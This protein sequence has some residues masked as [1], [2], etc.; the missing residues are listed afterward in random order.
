MADIAIETPTPK[1]PQENHSPDMI[2]HRFP[3]PPKS[4]EPEPYIEPLYRTLTAQNQTLAAQTH[5]ALPPVPHPGAPHIAPASEW[6][7]AGVRSVMKK[8]YQAERAAIAADTARAEAARSRW[9]IG[10]QDDASV[11]SDNTRAGPANGHCSRD[12]G[13]SPTDA[14]APRSA[15]T[16]LRSDTLIGPVAIRETSP[17][18]IEQSRGA[19]PEPNEPVREPSVEVVEVREAS[20]QLVEPQREPS[21]EFID[22]TRTPSVEIVE[23]LPAAVPQTVLRTE[24]VEAGSP[25]LC[26]SVR[27]DSLASVESVRA[28]SLKPADSVREVPGNSISFAREAPIISSP[29]H[30]S[31]SKGQK[32]LR[33]NKN[34]EESA[35]T[36]NGEDEVEQ[37]VPDLEGRMGRPRKVRRIFSLKRSRNEFER[38]DHLSV[39]LRD[40]GGRGVGGRPRKVRRT[41]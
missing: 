6:A 41:C 22:Q 23:Y 38:V 26:E 16:N 5:A 11:P 29:A 4:P 27:A 10:L 17:E 30:E 1:H 14:N 15:P 33:E 34:D 36:C 31:S 39:F 21:V 8:R 25:A 24:P 19:S 37:D 40:Q 7:K 3:D 2:C 9:K 18:Q 20:A 13:M 32:R 35:K 12:H 28:A